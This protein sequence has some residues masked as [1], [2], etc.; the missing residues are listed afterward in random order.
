VLSENTNHKV[1]GWVYQLKNT[2]KTLE[3]L[4]DYEG[5]STNDAEP[6][7]YVKQLVKVF[8]QTHEEVYCWVYI[9]NYS[10]DGLELIPS[11]DYLKFRSIL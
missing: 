9:Y 2:V 6:H 4:D 10:V 11:G 3:W 5:V 7:E 1:Y 8:L